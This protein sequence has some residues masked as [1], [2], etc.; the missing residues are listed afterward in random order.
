MSRELKV[1]LF[2]VAAIALLYFGFNYLKGIDFF[3]TTDKYYALYENVDGLNKSNAVYVNGF[4]VGRV[5]DITLIQNDDNIVAVELA[6]EGD[7]QLGDSARAILKSDFLG[8][9]S[10]VLDVGDLNDPIT[11]GDTI[12]GALDRAL[13]DILAESAQPVAN[14]LESTIKKLN[15]LLDN[16]SENS[17]HLDSFFIQLQEIPPVLE[18]TIRSVDRN[19]N[20]V[21]S[22]FEGVGNELNTT[23]GN[24]NPAINNLEQ[25]TDSL[26]QLELNE[27]V[28]QLNQ[29]VANLN[30]AIDK[31][32]NNE[33]TLGKLIHND[34]LY[35]NL[36]ETARSLDQLIYHLNTNPKHFFSPLGKKRSKIEKE[37]REQ[38]IEL[39]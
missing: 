12:I 8:N 31:I 29:T 7:L 37:L 1:G 17:A 5:S 21:T 2:M 4:I 14:S 24:L 36:N 18:H 30:Q 11:A 13:T 15:L 25:F 28:N 39:E 6:V 19:L 23:L 32:S 10:I 22:T 20:G 3:S 9:K 38:G 27:T 34:S 33:G 26:N 35:N 16:L